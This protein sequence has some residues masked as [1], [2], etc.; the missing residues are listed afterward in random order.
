MGIIEDILATPANIHA[1]F[2]THPDLRAPTKDFIM[3]GLSAFLT[4]QAVI[5]AKLPQEYIALSVPIFMAASWLLRYMQT[6][7][8]VPFIGAHLP[9]PGA[10]RK[11]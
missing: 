2:D 10:K 6:H 11:R 4:Y 7:S 3:A 1:W 5:T 8:T 9:A